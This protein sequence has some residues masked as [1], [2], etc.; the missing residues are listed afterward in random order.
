MHAVFANDFSQSIVSMYNASASVIGAGC[1]VMRTPLSSQSLPNDANPL[2][3]VSFIRGVTYCTAS[4]Y[5]QQHNFL[6]V[7]IESIAPSTY[8][9]VCI[10]G[11]CQA[12]VGTSAT[13]STGIA[14]GVD[15]TT[16]GVFI[17]MAAAS[18]LAMNSI[19]AMVLETQN[20]VTV[21]GF[22]NAFIEHVKIPGGAGKFT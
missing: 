2:S 17:G 10:G 18:A 4:V 22:V 19:P 13:Y 8:G 16:P 15:T 1:A 7:A 20:A 12:R 5:T 21:D 3:A 9:A 6:G 14:L 11:P